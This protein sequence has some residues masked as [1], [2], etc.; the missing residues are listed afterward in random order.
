VEKR[1]KLRQAQDESDTFLRGVQ[2]RAKILAILLYN[3]VPQEAPA[4]NVFIKA[5]MIGS[6]GSNDLLDERLPYSS[7]DIKLVF[8]DRM[9]DQERDRFH[10]RQFSFCPLKIRRPSSDRSISW[11]PLARAHM[12]F[13]RKKQCGEGASNVAVFYVDI[14]PGHLQDMNS[15]TWNSSVTRLAMKQIPFDKD[16]N[17]EVKVNMLI[18]VQAFEHKH[19]VQIRGI[20]W[21]ADA[22]LIF[23]EP[24]KCNL[25]EFMTIH[26][27][28]SAAT[29]EFRKARLQMFTKI[30]SALVQLHGSLEDDF[31]RIHFMH[32]DIKAENIL[33]MSDSADV[34][35]RQI[36]KLTDFGLSSIKAESSSASNRHQQTNGVPADR[37]SRTRLP[38]IAVHFAPESRIDNAVTKKSDV[39][40]FGLGSAEVVAWIAK[41]A[42]GLKDLEHKRGSEGL[43]NAGQDRRLPDNTSWILDEN[44]EP[45]LSPGIVMWFEILTTDSELEEEERQMYANCWLL[46]KHVCPACDPERRGGMVVVQ[47]FLQDICNGHR[48]VQA[49]ILSDF[50]EYRATHTTANMNLSEDVLVLS[51]AMTTTTTSTTD[52]SQRS[53]QDSV[54]DPSDILARRSTTSGHSSAATGTSPMQ[55]VDELPQATSA[56]QPQRSRLRSFVNRIIPSS[57]DGHSALPSGTRPNY[58]DVDVRRRTSST[59]H[60]SNADQRQRGPSQVNVAPVDRQRNAACGT[61]TELHSAA[62][63]GN[64]D[65]MTLLLASLDLDTVEGQNKLNAKDE[66]RMTP[67]LHALR[68]E[69]AQAAM[70][71]LDN[72]ADVEIIPDSGRSTLDYAVVIPPPDEDK[73]L[74]ALLLERSPALITERDQNGDTALHKLAE[75]TMEGTLERLEAM[76][77]VLNRA[78]GGASALDEALK[79]RSGPNHNGPLPCEMV[80][81]GTLHNRERE[82]IIELLTPGGHNTVRN[83][84]E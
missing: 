29:H 62:G 31:K 8:Q 49:N 32:K 1:Y 39:W 77:R 4:W 41:G 14:H 17:Q 59:S 18:Q 34:E 9:R 2:A 51:P 58:P 71:L 15:D 43:A 82:R 44:N 46:M 61:R 22:V 19:I 24:A 47:R 37:S 26:C 27:P 76:V 45:V 54:H 74:A 64:L 16:A 75:R 7:D 84:R 40:A 80:Q 66:N 33:V 67:L 83:T 42:E 5:C 72:S 70:L 3:R 50:P 21:L 65:Q 69:H 6:A 23:M 78:E 20:Y 48:G 25:Y 52:T 63:Q 30:A 38:A 55:S 56:E 73:C 13:V 79:S 60:N 81:E 35:T 36:L 57:R 11:I 68:E 53:R 12:P 10:D 28:Q